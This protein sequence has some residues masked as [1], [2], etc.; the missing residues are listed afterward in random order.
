MIFTLL[1][2]RYYDLYI[3]R[4]MY[5]SYEPTVCTITDYKFTFIF[6][7][8]TDRFKIHGLWPNGCIECPDCSYPSCCNIDKINYTEPFDP[9][10]FIEQNWY[11]SLTTNG[12]TESSEKVQLFEHE[13]YK[14]ASCTNLTSSTEFLNLTIGLYDQYYMKY[15]VPNCLNSNEIWLDLD[16]NY[17]FVK[18]ECK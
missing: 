18:F 1:L 6:D 17:E 15:V 11:Q 14:H 7:K 3:S 8:P 9:L 5:K 16:N 4:T 12:C 13:Y 10:N 2:F